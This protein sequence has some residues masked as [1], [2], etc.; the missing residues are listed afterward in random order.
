MQ[1]GLWSRLPFRKFDLNYFPRVQL[2]RGNGEGIANRK[3]CRKLSAK[4][5]KVVR[6]TLFNYVYTR[7]EL[8]HYTSRL[9]KMME[10]DKMTVRIHEVYHLK[11]VARAHDVSLGMIL[12]A[13]RLSNGPNRT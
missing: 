6:P 13:E 12:F 7:I 8:E 9:W 1:V 10:E 4:N 2:V 5:I 11:D 3:C